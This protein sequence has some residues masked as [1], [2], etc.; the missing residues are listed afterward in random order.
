MGSKSHAIALGLAVCAP[1]L[2]W[3]A[4]AHL[5]F[6]MPALGAFNRA[7]YHPFVGPGVTFTVVPGEASDAVVG[8]V[9]N[10]ST[11]ACVGPSDPNQK[12]GTGRLAF[13]RDGDIGRSGYPIQARF[14]PPLDAGDGEVF[15]EAQ[16][17]VLASTRVNVS[18]LNDA[19]D[20]IGSS[21]RLADSDRSNCGNPGN[22][23]ARVTLR[24]TCRGPVRYA[25]LRISPT[26]RVFVVDEFRF[27]GVARVEAATWSQIKNFYIP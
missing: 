20:I 23:R 26:N 13:G 11:S 6:E 12:L 7:V 22:L 5:D 15:V 17:Q 9:R 4:E 24:A 25:H 27:G 10:H 18:L 3:A 1:G 21:E 2:L 8:L 14:D 19:G 16:F